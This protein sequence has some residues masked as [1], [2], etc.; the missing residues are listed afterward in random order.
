MDMTRTKRSIA[1]AALAAAMA[2][3]GAAQDTLSVVLEPAPEQAGSPISIITDEAW[4]PA[5]GGEATNAASAPMAEPVYSANSVDAN[6][7]F[8]ALAR[9]AGL[10]YFDNPSLSGIKVS[11]RVRVTEP[12]QSIRD[13]AAAHKLVSYDSGQT[14]FVWT[15]EEMKAMPSRTETYQ[16]QYLRQ[17][18][19]EELIKPMLTPETGEVKMEAKSNTILIRDNDHAIRSVRDWLKVVDVPKRQINLQLI[20]ARIRQVRELRYGIDWQQ[21]LGENGYAV[22]F[23]TANSLRTLFNFGNDRYQPPD[24]DGELVPNQGNLGNAA[25]N[26]IQAA[27]ESVTAPTAAI[28]QPGIATV[29]LRALRQ[30]ADV[31]Q[32]ASP[33]LVLEDNED[34]V[35]SIVDR[36]P[37]VEFQPSGQTQ[38][39]FVSLSSEIRYKLDRED[40]SPTV[41]DP[42]REI[43]FSLAVTPTILPD[44]SIRVKVQ[45]RA[46]SIIE[47]REVPTG[48][49]TPP[50]EV[51]RVSESRSTSTLR[52][53]DGYSA[54]LGGFFETEVGKGE[55]KV[56][57]LGDIPV[58]NFFFK[59]RET[60]RNTT[61][62]LFVLTATTYDPLDTRAVERLD[63]AAQQPRPLPVELPSEQ[64]ARLRRAASGHPAPT[65]AP[66]PA[67]RAKTA[68]RGR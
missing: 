30:V 67:T 57:V 14:L 38:G 59:S 43:G 20:I 12:A 31:E 60:T 41:K 24:A 9:R 23:G 55:N 7:L 29:V 19:I 10:Q 5:A 64:E 26:G 39:D 49:D 25:Q 28:L 56:P 21:T 47:I 27:T 8:R 22:S 52:L 18:N 36:F 44:G 35:V 1:A 4:R 16:L 68:P 15:V 11:G 13:L 51:P 66:A 62:L 48:T 40:P 58:V 32:I 53:P 37:I 63:R 46:A 54:L 3:T 50:N 42:G 45:P 34:G 2:G 33:N 17:D 6:Q 61:R 65:P